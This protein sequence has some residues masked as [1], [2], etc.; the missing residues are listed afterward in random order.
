MQFIPVQ[1][2]PW[3]ICHVCSAYVSDWHGIS[4]IPP[5]RSFSCS[6]R[7]HTTRPVKLKQ[8]TP[9]QYWMNWSSLGHVYID[10]MM[11]TLINVHHCCPHS[12]LAHP[13]P[14]AHKVRMMMKW[15]KILRFRYLLYE[16]WLKQGLPE[17]MNDTALA[18]CFWTPQ[19]VRENFVAC[20][21]YS[22]L[23]SWQWWP[24]KFLTTHHSPLLAHPT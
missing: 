21:D 3:S 20:R 17:I 10:H 7:C 5:S 2:V 22:W 11:K 18:T 6:S 15:N 12:C 23:S 9:H 19:H 4:S 24:R 8:D 1:D 13:H 14:H 16:V